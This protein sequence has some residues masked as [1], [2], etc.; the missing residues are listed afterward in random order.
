MTDSDRDKKAAFIDN[1]SKFILSQGFDSVT[2]MAT[3]Y[4]KD[5]VATSYWTRGDG[6][7]MARFG[8]AKEWVLREEAK[9]ASGEGRTQ[10]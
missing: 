7:F 8:Q 5:D 4:D 2:I 10:E 1:Q 3:H 9:I 6:N